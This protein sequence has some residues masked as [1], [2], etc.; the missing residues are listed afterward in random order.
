VGREL[1]KIFGRGKKL[2]AITKFSSL[3]SGKTC[4]VDTPIFIYFLENHPRFD[5]T[6]REFFKLVEAGKTQAITSVI[7]PIEVL[8]SKLISE[9]TS[10]LYL[11]FFH[12]FNNLRIQEVG[13]D[14]VPE[15]SAL[16]R[17]YSLRTPDAIQIAT[18][19]AEG[20]EYFLTNDARL[21]KVSQ[22]K[23]ILLS[24]FIS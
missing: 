6:S 20:A 11:N 5:K 10:R 22:I 23:V 3:V 2:M 15:I 4:G 12:N 8:S 9:Q 17:Q 13:L 1:S 18:A 21:K 19:I 16:R 7:T 24:D 14:L